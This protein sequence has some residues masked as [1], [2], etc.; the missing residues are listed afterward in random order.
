MSKPPH[1]PY[2]FSF[3][4]SFSICLLTNP[5]AL[6]L[7][8]PNLTGSIPPNCTASMLPDIFI[9]G[10]VGVNGVA[11]AE[12][13]H[14]PTL[15]NSTVFAATTSI[16]SSPPGRRSETVGSL[17]PNPNPS[18]AGVVAGA[19]SSECVLSAELSRVMG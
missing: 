7:A 17:P 5:S 6:A 12:F 8:S 2:R 1:R 19:E 9:P 16:L 13:D 4:L 18:P 15:P 10:P 3:P 14:S 11:I